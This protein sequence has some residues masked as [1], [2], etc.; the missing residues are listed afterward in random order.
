MKT[1]GIIILLIILIS[2]CKEE[3]RLDFN[4]KDKILVVEGGIT[5]NVGPYQIRL[6]TSLPINQPLRVPYENCVVAIS[7]NTGTNEILKETEPG[8]YI[9]SENGIQGTV[10]NEYSLSVKTPDGKEYKTGFVEMKAPVQ[11]DS[12]YAELNKIEDLDYPFGLP[13]YQ[14]YVDTKPVSDMESYVLWNLTETYQYE[15]DYKLYALYF[16][17]DMFYVKTDMDQITDITKLNYDTLYTCWRTETVK[18]IYTGQ[19]ANLVTPVI[20]KQP[21]NFV[22]TET[23]KLSIRYSLLVQ[24]YTI[25]RDAYKFWESIEDQITDESFLNTKQ[26]Y[27]I[28]G[29]LININ[30]EKEVTFGYFTVASVDKKRIYYNRPN[31]TFYF[32]KGYTAEPIDLNKKKQPVYLILKENSMYVVHEDCVDCRTEGGVI[33]KPDFWIDP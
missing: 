33:D 23:K 13:G 3:F 10:G 30:D 28:S 32:E 31:T 14:F 26:P 20:K 21:L 29:N 2:G 6:S 25:S 11:I 16:Y 8:V 15:A 7:D 18:D 5:N 12:V 1:R 24:Q 9:T 4:T 27:N 17:G 19:T 22:T